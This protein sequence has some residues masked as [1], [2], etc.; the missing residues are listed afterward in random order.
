[1]SIESQTP[2]Q[3]R[4]S[5]KKRF[6]PRF[7]EKSKRINQIDTTT[8]SESNRTKLNYIQETLN[9]IDLL[10][11]NQ[12]KIFLG[13]FEEPLDFM[14]KLDDL[15]SSDE[16]MISINIKI[17]FGTLSEGYKNFKDEEHVSQFIK[18]DPNGNVTISATS[19]TISNIIASGGDI[20]I[21]GNK[22]KP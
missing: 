14:A 5:G 17:V 18:T 16:T 11:D 15:L 12:R 9:E 22:I 4:D 21:N 1:M 2:S 7:S 20:T 6:A 3:N 19:G 8:L 10:D 13:S